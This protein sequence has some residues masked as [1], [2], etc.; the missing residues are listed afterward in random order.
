VKR[1]F[2][3]SMMALFLL[4]TTFAGDK[5]EAASQWRS[6]EI[7]IDGADSEWSGALA[8]FEKTRLA[9]ALRNDSSDIYLCLEFEPEI[10][11]QVS[12]FGF[13]VW[14]DANG[15]EKKTFGVRFPI[16]L[17]NFDD[18]SMPDPIAMRENPEA[19]QSQVALMRRE[20]E[21][22]G[23]DKDDRNR[24]AVNGVFGIQAIC[25]EASAR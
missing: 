1:Q 10:R 7:K 6:A 14:F 12:M 5:K 11:R 16:G 20:I 3:F 2:I 19:F 9:Y 18:A 23:P 17:F 13:T 15:K 21:M 24:F 22:I 4:G 8:Y 25:A